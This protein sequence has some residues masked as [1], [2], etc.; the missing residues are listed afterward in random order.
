MTRRY[1]V[2]NLIRATREKTSC[3]YMNGDEYVYG[4]VKQSCDSETR[5]SKHHS[6][7]K[8]SSSLKAVLSGPCV[9]LVQ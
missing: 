3:M 1:I 7:L 4:T 8:A 5:I 6:H 2:S 9:F